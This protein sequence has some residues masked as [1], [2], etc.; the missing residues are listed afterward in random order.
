MKTLVL[1]AFSFAAVAQPADPTP[2][3]KITIE[4]QAQWL[5]SRAELAEARLALKNAEDRFSQIVK[6]IMSVCPAIV[7][8]AGRPECPPPNPP[9]APTK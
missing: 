4:Q 1:F 6:E 8:P 9:K 7:S 3:P 2:A 5:Q